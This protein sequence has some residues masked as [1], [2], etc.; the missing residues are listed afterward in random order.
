MTGEEPGHKRLQAYI[1][2]QP[3]SYQAEGLVILNID[4]LTGLS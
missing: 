1:P 3:G 4:V 2:D